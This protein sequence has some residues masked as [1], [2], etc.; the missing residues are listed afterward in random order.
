[1]GPQR[2]SL[3]QTETVDT[4][5]VSKGNDNQELEVARSGQQEIQCNIFYMMSKGLG[6]LT[7]HWAER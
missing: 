1:M 5:E 7:L 3:R 4:V 6:R 2:V